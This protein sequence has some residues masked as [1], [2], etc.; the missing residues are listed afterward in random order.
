LGGA[1]RLPFLGFLIFSLVFDFAFDFAFFGMADHFQNGLNISVQRRI[2]ARTGPAVT[3]RKDRYQP[4]AASASQPKTLKTYACARD[5]GRAVG[6]K[7]SLK[8]FRLDVSETPDS[9]DPQLAKATPPLRG[10]H[11]WTG[12]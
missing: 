7:K 8:N 12:F 9:K 1:A 2:M 6:R 5:C 3:R 11:I 4:R 10:V